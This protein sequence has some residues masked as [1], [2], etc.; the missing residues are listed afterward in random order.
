[1]RAV[2]VLAGDIRDDKGA[3]AWIDHAGWIVCAD[4]GARHLR[5]LGRLPDLLVGDLD[6]AH[7]EDVAW[8]IQNDVPLDKFPMAKDATDSELAIQAALDHLDHL[9]HFDHLD[10]H[11]VYPDHLAGLPESSIPAG[12]RI[13]HEL[14]ILGAFGSRPDHVLAN[15]LLAA[16]L[17]GL[18]WRLILTDGISRLHTLAGGQ[19][20]HVELPEAP[21]PAGRSD[22][23]GVWAFSIVPVTPEI[24]GLT[25]HSGLVWPL[26]DA[27]LTLGTS[28]AVSNRFIEARQKDGKLVFQATVSLESGIALVIVTPED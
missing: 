17:A 26:A 14:V 25:Y 2:V 27:T 7:P 18:G 15:Q 23:P 12:A 21:S 13:S 16:K 9:D 24:T 28:R 11:A 8:M 6:S 10:H 4:G 22:C 5:R 20:L 19:T 3:L 1:M